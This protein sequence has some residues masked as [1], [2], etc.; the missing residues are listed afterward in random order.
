MIFLVEAINIDCLIVFKI[1]VFEDFWL[2][3]VI[4]FDAMPLIGLTR[5]FSHVHLLCTSFVDDDVII[6]LDFRFII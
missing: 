3:Q 1:D 4:V 6:S 5:D 2:F